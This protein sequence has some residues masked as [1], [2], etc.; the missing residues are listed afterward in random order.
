MNRCTDRR[1]D[2]WKE[3]WMDEWMDRWPEETGVSRHGPLAGSQVYP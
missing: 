1:T 3:K 2:N